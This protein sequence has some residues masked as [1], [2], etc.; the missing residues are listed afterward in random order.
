MLFRSTTLVGVGTRSA[1]FALL[2]MTLVI[3]VFVYPGAWPTHGTW[4][5]ILLLLMARGP[6]SLSLDRALELERAR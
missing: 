2:L 4:A 6:G 5:A 3:E 1:A